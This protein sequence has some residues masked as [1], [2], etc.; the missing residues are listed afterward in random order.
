MA[1][2]CLPKVLQPDRCPVCGHRHEYRPHDRLLRVRRKRTFTQ[3]LYAIEEQLELLR[4]GRTSHPRRSFAKCRLISRRNASAEPRRAMTEPI[5]KSVP[6]TRAMGLLANWNSRNCIV[7]AATAMSAT[8]QE[9]WTS[10]T[11]PLASSMPVR[12]GK[13]VSGN[14]N[15]VSHSGSFAAT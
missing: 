9:A 14:Q 3:F 4:L 5:T 12:R 10:E 6:T 8:T 2:M 13:A 15:H 11:L 7:I 1:W